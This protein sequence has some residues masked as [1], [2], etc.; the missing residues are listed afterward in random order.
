MR[1]GEESLSLSA[2]LTTERCTCCGCQ[3]AG[4]FTS[5]ATLPRWSG[6]KRRRWVDL[7][8]STVERIPAPRRARM[9]SAS[10]S[11]R[12]TSCQV[13]ESFE[14][15]ACGGRCCQ[16]VQQVQRLMESRDSCHVRPVLLDG[17]KW[18]GWF[19]DTG[20]QMLCDLFEAHCALTRLPVWNGVNPVARWGL[21]DLI[22]AET[23]WGHLQGWTWVASLERQSEFLRLSSNLGL[24][25]AFTTSRAG[26]KMTWLPVWGDFSYFLH[27]VFRKVSESLEEWLTR[28]KGE[29]EKTNTD[30]YQHLF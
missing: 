13:G 14:G 3:V 30:R 17:V 19:G 24:S 29:D 8:G 15:E 5:R 2:Y 7:D 4:R 6:S 18:S 23:R 21:E 11:M 9:W 25:H 27:L 12:G 26:W 16:D 10:V 20:A 28:T 1:R 22:P